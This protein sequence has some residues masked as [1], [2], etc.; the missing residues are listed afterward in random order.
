MSALTDMIRSTGRLGFCHGLYLVVEGD[1]K[2]ED[3]DPLYDKYDHQNKVELVRL[4]RVLENTRKDL[5]EAQ[6]KI[7]H[8]TEMLRAH[9]GK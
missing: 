7:E 8:L 5:A 4:R 1:F 2:K 3:L 9:Q 6:M